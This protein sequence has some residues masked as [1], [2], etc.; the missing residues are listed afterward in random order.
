M[1]RPIAS[2]WDDHGVDIEATRVRVL[3][4]QDIRQLLR[5]G[6]VT[7]VVA[8]M[9]APLRWLNGDAVFEFWKREVRPRVLGTE[10]FRLEDFPGEYGYLEQLA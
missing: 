5:D 8:D 4:Q 2:L 1:H 3:E 7:F 6:P 10:R 9:G